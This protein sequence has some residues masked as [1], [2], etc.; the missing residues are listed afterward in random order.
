MLETINKLKNAIMKDEY[1]RKLSLKLGVKEESLILESKRA[2]QPKL[3]AKE[4]QVVSDQK[5]AFNTSP[6]EKLL[7]SL[8][9][10]ENSLI[11]RMKDN[12]SPQDFKDERIC[13]I[14][15][16]MFDLVEEGREV[17]PQILMNH[18]EDDISSLICRSEFLPEGL[19]LEHK[20]RMADDCLKRIKEEGVKLKRERLHEEIKVAQHSGDEQKLNSLIEE[21]HSLIKKR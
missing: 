9:L 21:F 19:T 8:M 4:R 17:R 16:V 1:L 5:G 11:N 10:E 13:R 20:E 14:V 2:K 7:M 3:S 12:L 15:S 6:T 18:L